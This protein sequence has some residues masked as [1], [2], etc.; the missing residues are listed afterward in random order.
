MSALYTS[1]HLRGEAGAEIEE[2]DA[3]EAEVEEA[4]A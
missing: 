2:A 1:L 4:D 3:D